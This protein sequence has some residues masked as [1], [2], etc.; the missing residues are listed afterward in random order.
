MTLAEYE[1]PNGAAPA[2][3]MTHSE[4]EEVISDRVYEH[5]YSLERFIAAPTD[6][7]RDA[8]KA[9]RTSDELAPPALIDGMFERATWGSL[10]EFLTVA[11]DAPAVER[12]EGF[13]A[14]GV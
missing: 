13:E 5:G 4:A 10:A 7:E 14:V 1:A 9:L 11:W 12:V 8:V 3:T 6:R 2:N